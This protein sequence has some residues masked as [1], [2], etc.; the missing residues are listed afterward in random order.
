MLRRHQEQ[1]PLIKTTCK[2]DSESLSPSCLLLMPCTLTE[3]PCPCFACSPG[4][5]NTL[6]VACQQHTKYHNQF[7]AMLVMNCSVDKSRVMQAVGPP[8]RQD[9][10]IQQ[11]RRQHHQHAQQQAVGEQVPAPAAAAVQQGEGA[12]AAASAQPQDTEAAERFWPVSCATCGTEVGVVDGDEVYHF[13]HVFPS[14]A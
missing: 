7:R 12:D 2:M 6:T 10:K 11:E 9:G 13:F 3:T 14:T 4:C 8:S 5:F 1:Q